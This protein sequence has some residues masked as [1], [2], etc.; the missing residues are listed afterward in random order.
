MRELWPASCLAMP[1][2]VTPSWATAVLY[3][4][5]I[6]AAIVHRVC[7]ILRV[8]F[9]LRQTL[10][11]IKCT[12]MD[13]LLSIRSIGVT[14]Y[15]GPLRSDHGFLIKC[16]Y[17]GLCR[18]QVNSSTCTHSFGYFLSLLVIDKLYIIA[19]GPCSFKT[20][21]SSLVKT[22]WNCLF[23]ETFD[24]L[25]KVQLRWWQTMPNYIPN[26]LFCLIF[27]LKCLKIFEV[28]WIFLRSNIT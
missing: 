27:H 18:V 28:T 10:K 5:S 17:K 4:W 11:Q 6:Q 22:V 2:I 15:F 19:Y 20:L 21:S 13:L 1:L 3:G 9:K 7:Q 12:H 8:Y 25:S 16:L 26:K 14:L 23:E 24:L